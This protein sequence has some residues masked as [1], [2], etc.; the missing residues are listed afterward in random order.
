MTPFPCRVLVRLD[1]SLALFV[2]AAG[3]SKD[4]GFSMP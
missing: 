3:F 1:H 4:A 2:S